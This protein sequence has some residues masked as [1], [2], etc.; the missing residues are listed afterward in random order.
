MTNTLTLNKA[1][2][3]NLLDTIPPFLLV[4][5]INDGMELVPLMKSDNSRQCFVNQSKTGVT[6]KFD[7][8]ADALKDATAISVHLTEDNTLVLHSSPRMLEATR[9]SA[10]LRVVK[11]PIIR[12]PSK[13]RTRK[14]PVNLKPDIRRGRYPK[15]IEHQEIDIPRLLMGRTVALAEVT[16]LSTKTAFLEPVAK[17]PEPKLVE[18]IRAPEQQLLPAPEPV[19]EPTTPEPEPVKTSAFE[20]ALTKLWGGIPIT[21]DPVKTAELEA[22]T[23]RRMQTRSIV[24]PMGS[25]RDG[26]RRARAVEVVVKRRRA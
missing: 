11:Q 10:T 9:P 2:V 21:V 14:P 26:T 6:I 22:P 7:T 24:I 15:I 16:G 1:A 3:E 4:R 19:C 17:R 25:Q 23:Q 20:R 12:E 8:N 18:V 5:E 13:V